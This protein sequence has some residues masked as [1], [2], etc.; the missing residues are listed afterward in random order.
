MGQTYQTFKPRD[1]IGGDVRYMRRHEAAWAMADT[2]RR[3]ED[4]ILDGSCGQS[5]VKNGF[6]TIHLPDSSILAALTSYV[7]PAEFV[8]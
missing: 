1:V 6:R 3:G 2:A 7:F 8:T 4:V 5:N